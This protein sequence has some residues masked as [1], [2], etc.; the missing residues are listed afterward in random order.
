MAYTEYFNI[1]NQDDGNDYTNYYNGC[2]VDYTNYY[3][4]CSAGHYNVATRGSHYYNYYNKCSVDYTNY[5]NR[6]THAYRNVW[7]Y[8]APDKGTDH[9]AP[10]WTSPWGGSH[11]NRTLNVTY[12]EESVDAIKKLR[13]ELK[14]FE[15]RR[16]NLKVTFTTDL[17]ST[18]PRVG[19]DQFNDNN[20]ATPEKV[21]DDQ[22]DAIK[23]SIDNLWNKVK[24]TSSGLPVKNPGEKISKTDLEVMANKLDNM[25]T[26][27]TASYYAN[28][29][30][31]YY[32][33]RDN[34]PTESQVN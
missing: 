19:D 17:S 18:S 21:E 32:T 29:F 11:G 4:R 30:N 28:H 23:E 31:T 24:G 10:S 2:S 25:T 1:V 3:N 13:D 27:T 34:T 7:S 14:A 26:T 33:H 6:C 16:E 22:Y 5:T 12:I 15:E 9:T 20:P 8:K